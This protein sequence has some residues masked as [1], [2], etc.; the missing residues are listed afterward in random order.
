MLY[1]WAT[2][3]S[4]TAWPATQCL[5]A[6]LWTDRTHLDYEL[7]PESPDNFM[8]IPYYCETSVV[9]EWSSLG[10]ANARRPAGA[11]S[12]ERWA[13]NIM[14]TPVVLS[15]SARELS[16]HR[17]CLWQT[18]HPQPQPRVIARQPRTIAGPTSIV[19][20]VVAVQPHNSRVSFH[21]GFVSAQLRRDCGILVWQRAGACEV[22]VG[23]QAWYLGSSVWGMRNMRSS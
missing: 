14:I 22:S 16:Q 20:P 9:S 13:H 3:G 5:C 10:N 17:L 18:L 7:R 15:R 21:P 4:V 23:E 19:Q 2:P 11:R 8:F 6:D 1:Y 12:V